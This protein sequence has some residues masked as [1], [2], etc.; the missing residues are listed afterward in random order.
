[1]PSID[2]NDNNQ[3]KTPEI[4]I[5]GFIFLA[6]DAKS[7]INYHSILNTK[8]TRLAQVML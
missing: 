4:Q 3:H 8:I 2:C 1:M 6:F 5:S 7:Y